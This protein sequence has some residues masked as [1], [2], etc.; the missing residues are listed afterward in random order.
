LDNT[1]GLIVGDR[2]L[3]TVKDTVASGGGIGFVADPT[4]AYAEIDLKGC[5]ASGNFVGILGPVTPAV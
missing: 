3:A 5:V 4:S 2:E 1:L